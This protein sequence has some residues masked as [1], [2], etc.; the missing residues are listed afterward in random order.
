MW[1][2]VNVEKKLV[3]LSLITVDEGEADEPLEVMKD[4]TRK[5]V[6]TAS[7]EEKLKTV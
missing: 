6:L 3:E 5:P 1:L 7:E 4:G 2:Q